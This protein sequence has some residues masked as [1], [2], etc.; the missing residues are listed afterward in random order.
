MTAVNKKRTIAAV[1]AAVIA[2]SGLVVIAKYKSVKAR[3]ERQFYESVTQPVA[4]RYEFERQG[5]EFAYAP[6]KKTD[7]LTGKIEIFPYNGGDTVTLCF[8]GDLSPAEEQGSLH[9]YEGAGIYDYYAELT[10]SI[11]NGGKRDYEVHFSPTSGSDPIYVDIAEDGTFSYPSHDDTKITDVQL[12]TAEKN[13]L[14]G[15][16]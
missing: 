6:V 8:R 7:L 15:R 14:L 9:R 4:K 13:V 16:V 10:C 12:Q 3:E 5:S 2:V 1:T 11:H